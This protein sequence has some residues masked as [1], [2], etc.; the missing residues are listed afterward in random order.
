MDSEGYEIPITPGDL[1][2]NIDPCNER[3]QSESDSFYLLRR[4]SHSCTSLTSER[5][6]SDS[7]MQSEEDG[8]KRKTS[9][10]N[11]NYEWCGEVPSDRH[12]IEQANYENLASD[13][14]KLNYGEDDIFNSNSKSASLCMQNDAIERTYS[15]PD[16]GVGIEIATNTLTY[17]KKAA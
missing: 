1:A 4:N 2:M 10:V 16:S 9:V 17:H 8:E 3:L 15:E 11:P 7:G 6:G 12:C 13:V 5:L 14:N